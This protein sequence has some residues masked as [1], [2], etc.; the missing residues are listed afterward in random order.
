MAGI[1]DINTT[2]M[3]AIYSEIKKLVPGLSAKPQEVGRALTMA[4]LMLDGFEQIT[5]DGK[6][7]WLLSFEVR[8]NRADCFSVVGIAREVAAC[9]GLKLVLPKVAVKKNSL[10]SK[11][12]I[13]IAVQSGDVKRILALEIDDSKNG[14]SPAWL[15]EFLKVYGLNSKNL[16]VDLSNYVMIYTGYPSHLIDLEKVK[17]SIVWTRAYAKEKIM[18]LDGTII[19]LPEDDVL[20]IKDEESI[21]ALAGI[22]GGKSA[23]ISLQTSKLFVEMAVYGGAVIRKNSRDVKVITEASLRLEKDLDPEGA[24]GAFDLLVSL[25]LESCFGKIATQVFEYY[26]KVA[27][28]KKIDFDLSLPGVISGVEVPAFEAVKI[29]KN[30][31]FSVR[32]KNKKTVVVSIP[33]FRTDISLPEDLVEEVLRINGYDKIPAGLAPVF[34]TADEITPRRIKLVK[35]MKEILSQNGADEILSLPLTEKNENA[36]ANYLEWETIVAENAINEL[37]PELRQSLASGL[38]RQAVEF[39]KKNVTIIDLFENGKIFGRRGD[40]YL[41]QESFGALLV[42]N[43]PALS[44]FK[45]RIETVLRLLGISEIDY[46]EAAKKPELCNPNSCWIIKAKGKS[47]GIVY[48]LKRGFLGGNTYFAELDVNVLEGI[49]P[50][51]APVVEISDKLVVLDMNIQTRVGERIESVINEIKAKVSPKNLWSL[52]V[53]DKFVENEV[54]K[55]TVRITYTGLSDPEAKKINARIL[56][57]RQSKKS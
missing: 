36:K 53:I 47:C 10:T 21:L 46:A 35:K 55:H 2:K 7:D 43:K 33:A 38:I 6:T 51:A 3:K 16:L 37:Y 42:A 22:V 26:P 40:R 52:A 1:W 11:M 12:P 14:E 50:D 8:Q 20:A 28:G 39:Q 19:V 4:G 23:E 57:D 34:E 29:L 31:G 27:L 49:K 41:E 5:Y 18:T 13:K 24:A 25:I 9:F 56:N 45:A 54:A 15:K 48:K 30:L 44:F 17:G 32:Q